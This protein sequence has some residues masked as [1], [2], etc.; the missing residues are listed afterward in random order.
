MRDRELEGSA[1]R[2]S[3]DNRREGVGEVDAGTLPKAMNHPPCFVPL[4]SAVETQLMLEDPLPTDH[5]G[6]PWSW[7]ELPCLVP[8]QGVELFHA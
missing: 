2:A 3:F 8:L 7:D 6:V 1:D 4:K 5:I